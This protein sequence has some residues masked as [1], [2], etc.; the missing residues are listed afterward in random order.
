MHSEMS[1]S[2]TSTYSYAMTGP[3]Q[4]QIVRSSSASRSRWQNLVI[5]AGVTA[6][7]IGAAVSEE[8]MKSLKYCLHWLHYA[9]AHLDHQVGV[10]RDFILSL[11]SQ[12]RSN[13]LVRSE[14]SRAAE[15]LNGIK[16]DVVETIRKVVDVVSKYAGAAL[17]EQA[18]R[19]V[20][21]SILG[22][23]E[24]WAQAMQGVPN[25][26]I[27]AAN[28]NGT[29]TGAS[30][31]PDNEAD[32][33]QA[34][35]MGTTQ[36]A[37]ERTLTF[38]VESLDMLRGVLNIFNDSVER[39]DAYV[40]PVSIYVALANTVLCSWVERLRLVGLQRQQALSSNPQRQGRHG[41]PVRSSPYPSI[42]SPL[43]NSTSTINGNASTTGIKRREGEDTDDDAELHQRRKNS[44]TSE[45]RQSGSVEVTQS[46]NMEVDA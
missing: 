41:L 42:A 9:T 13:A 6:G 24:R 27:L 44:R 16:R 34:T 20:R 12:H 2:T 17:P 5:E 31:G 3:P 10:L 7:G 39:A 21:S 30:S 38:A 22:L 36:A 1:L 4:T 18:R 23:P 43:S 14:D 19:Y 11:S 37:A 26:P 40:Q 46:A 15:I 8:S 29:E 32:R 25:Q 33:Q 28:A 35:P 45:V